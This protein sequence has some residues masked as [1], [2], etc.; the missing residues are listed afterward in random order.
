MLEITL[1]HVQ[2]WNVWYKDSNNSPDGLEPILRQVDA[3]A[4]AVGRDPA[5]IE[6]TTA[7]LVRLPGGTGRVMGDTTQADVPPLQGSP[8]AIADRL[9]DYATLGVAE[10]Q[11]VVDPITIESVTV[12]APVLRELDRG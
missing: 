10:V 7:V 1:P 12:L 11:L 6:K 9:R 4:R 2:L 3:A 5:K 8:Q